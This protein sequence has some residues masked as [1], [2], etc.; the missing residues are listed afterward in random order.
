MPY[1]ARDWKHGIFYHLMSR[2]NWKEL[3]FRD[4]NDYRYFY[5]L[6]ESAYK[7]YPFE[8]S[9][10]I[11][12]KTHFHLLIKSNHLDYSRIMQYIKKNYSDYFNKKYQ[13]RGHLFDKRFIAKPAY[14]HRTLLIMSRYIHYNPIEI[15]AVRNPED[16]KWSSYPLFLQADF[17]TDQDINLPPFIN[18]RPLLTSFSGTYEEKRLK[19]IQWC[20]VTL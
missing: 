20:N 6:L 10:F 19:Y 15:N 5:N 12:M 8:V 9:S 4:E 16:Y 3:M 2:S 17:N 11:F 13:L 18:F 7:K 1:K 14:N